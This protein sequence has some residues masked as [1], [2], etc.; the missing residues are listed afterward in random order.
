MSTIS[1]QRLYEEQRLF[2]AYRRSRDPHLREQLVGRYLPLARSL[3]RRYSRGGEALED[4]EQV[5]SLAL[6]KA[7]DGFDLRRGVAF[8]SY[9]VPSIAGAIKRHY[10]DIG[11]MV[12]PPRDMQ[13]LAV[14]VVRINDELSASTGAPAT[15]AQIAERLGV[16]VE[17][18][19]E[20]RE[21]HHAMR[22]ES[23]DKPHRTGDNDEGVSLLDTISGPEGE[24]ARLRD[25]L[26]IESLLDALNPRDRTVVRL[27]YQHNL[28]QTEIG[29]RLGYSQMHVSRILRTAVAK[30]VREASGE[31]PPPRRSDG[32]LIRRR[33]ANA[34]AQRPQTGRGSSAPTLDG[35][36]RSA[37]RAVRP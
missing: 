2:R 17:A 16:C 9:A 33:F 6:V 34:P 25:R 21:A 37:P 23:L 11:W 28:T 30:L 14:N 15:A 12:R 27:H 18:V 22:C 7:I 31:P 1:P 32:V 3:A 4:L 29:Q 26:T 19:V 20:A 13:D 5:A 10:R 24:L 8:S 36:S 35:F